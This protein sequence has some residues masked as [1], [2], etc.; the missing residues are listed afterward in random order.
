[1]ADTIGTPETVNIVRTEDDTNDIVIHLTNADGTD[2]TVT[3]WTAVLSLGL[4]NNTPLSPPQTFT[5]VGTIGGKIPI[6]MNGFNV[7]I[8]TYS[9]DVRV[10]DTVTLDTPSRTY[11]KGKF[12]VTE[13]IN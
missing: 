7:A 12:K 2:A 6:N 3:G 8:G 10:T 5:G 1:M 11:F 13:R 4:D 9:Y